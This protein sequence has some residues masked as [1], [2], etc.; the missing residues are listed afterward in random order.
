MKYTS[1]SVRVWIPWLEILKKAVKNLQ[2]DDPELTIPEY[3]RTRLGPT[4]AKD[5]GVELP[6][7]PP[8]NKRGR[9]SKH[10]VAAAAMGMSLNDWRKQILDEVA[11]KAIEKMGSGAP[12]VK[13]IKRPRSA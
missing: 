1:L 6:D 10:T 12:P 5:A 3:V 7:F 8:L 9:R 11:E 4:M 2:K 13:P